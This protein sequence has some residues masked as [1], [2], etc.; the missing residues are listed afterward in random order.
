VEQLGTVATASGAEAADL[1]QRA[2]QKVAGAQATASG[3]T[4][5][6]VEAN[7]RE[8]AQGRAE[9]LQAATV[10]MEAAE[11]NADAIARRE[12]NP[13]RLWNN[14]TGWQKATMLLSTLAYSLA[15][16]RLDVKA[17]NPMIVQFQKMV[18][19]DVQSQRD[20]NSRLLTNAKDQRLNILS[21]K[22][23]A[24]GSQE[25]KY[26][27]TISRITAADRYLQQLASSAG[28][29]ERRLAGIAMARKEMATM[30]QSVSTQMAGVLVSSESQARSFAH[31]ERMAK[32]ESDARLA[33]TLAKGETKDA[34][35]RNIPANSGLKLVR[36]RDEKGNP[37]NLTPVESQLHKDYVEKAT[38]VATTANALHDVL[39]RMEKKLAVAGSDARV[40]LKT[41]AEFNQDLQ[42]A[43]RYL[44]TQKNF[45]VGATTN[46]DV[47]QA[48]GVVA[49]QGESSLISTLANITDRGEMALKAVR[50]YRG[51]MPRLV[52]NSLQS[53]PT[54]IAG[55][56]LQWS[57]PEE[58]AS[59]V[60]G[61][62]YQLPGEHERSLLQTQEAEA[63]IPSTVTLNAPNPT[64]EGA[65]F[66]KATPNFDPAGGVIPAPDVSREVDRLPS[67]TNL[68]VMS[69]EQIRTAQ[70]VEQDSEGMT[71]RGIMALANA[72]LKDKG[73]VRRFAAGNEER[74]DQVRA[75]ERAIAL[76]LVYKAGKQLDPNKP[77]PSNAEIRRMMAAADFQAGKLAPED[78]EN[79][80]ALVDQVAAQE[81]QRIASEP[82]RTA[83]DSSF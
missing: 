66:S 50:K 79:I 76:D 55:D 42:L 70:L 75:R 47:S 81:R 71:A 19:A 64:L 28:G 32:I 82:P 26:A 18:E 1:G 72:K 30:R 36:G 51:E 3:V 65:G 39:G 27:H 40:L 31:Q 33:A 68:P 67:A 80:R 21:E 34:D 35:L 46:P 73:V 37:V 25:Q 10:K 15:T 60:D 9:A 49:G 44:A 7:N 8:A 24:L 45:N 58:E 61:S 23:D 83:Y 48:G 62:K 2:A 52:N 16:S 54:P 5:Q 59:A 43:A 4:L 41:D 78:Y 22:N 17:I 38:T 6:Q 29:D 69:P 77:D 63:G 14:S 74:L 12:P 13:G 56:Y 11:R 20:V 53:F 57:P